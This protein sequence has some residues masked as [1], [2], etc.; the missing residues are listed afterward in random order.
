VADPNPERRLRDEEPFLTMRSAPRRFGVGVPVVFLGAIGVGMLLA[1]WNLAA[2][3]AAMLVTQTGGFLWLYLPA[4]RRRL[5]EE[6]GARS[7]SGAP[8]GD[9][10]SE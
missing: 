10:T 1:G 9:P 7:G 5:R 3:L 8:E 4:L 2:G 6:A